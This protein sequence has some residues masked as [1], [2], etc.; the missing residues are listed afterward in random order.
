MTETHD[1]IV[2]SQFGPRAD[3]YVSSAVHASGADLDYI[4]ERARDL[5][6]CHALDLGA[7]GG[8][9]TYQLAACAEAVTACDLSEEMIAAV[10]AQAKVRE[11]NNVSGKVARAES[12]PFADDSFD[13]LASRFSA[14][15]W[16]DLEAG[17]REARRVLEPDGTALFIDVIAPEQPR[18]DVHLQAVELL[19]DT[20]HV[21]DYRQSE[22]IAS[23]GRAG[24]SV[25]ASR[26]WRLRMDFVSWVERMRTPG[27][28][29]AAI[30][31]LQRQAPE[32]IVRHFGIEEDGSF[33][34][35][36]AMIEAR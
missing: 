21:R 20:S 15:H 10:L 17:L 11:M 24:F 29:V 9:V 8:H 6:P 34:I 16:Q 5:R 27:D 36:V 23:L 33:F 2:R 12:L 31:S 32:E 30:R 22:W 35:D 18:A 14:H 25:T 3:A 26:C 28:H 7:G 19:R 1:A 13:F 4:A